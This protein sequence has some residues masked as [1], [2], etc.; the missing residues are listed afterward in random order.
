MQPANFIRFETEDL[1]PD[2]VSGNNASVL[3]RTKRAKD[4]AEQV[5][6]PIQQLPFGV[7]P[8]P[9]FMFANDK[10]Y[11]T[12]GPRKLAPNVHKSWLTVQES[13]LLDWYRAVISY[14]SDDAATGSE[15]S[16]YA[17]VYEKDLPYS[18]TITTISSTRIQIFS[19]PNNP[20]RFRTFVLAGNKQGGQW[21]FQWFISD[22][23]DTGLTDLYG[24]YA[25]TLPIAF[26]ANGFTFQ[27]VFWDLDFVNFDAENLE[28]FSLPSK[29]FDQYRINLLP[30]YNNLQGVSSGYIGLVDADGNVVDEVVGTFA[31]PADTNCVSVVLP[32]ISTNGAAPAYIS[33]ADFITSLNG[34]SGDSLWAATGFQSANYS[35]TDAATLIE[36]GIFETFGEWSEITWPTDPQ[37]FI[38]IISNFVFIEVIGEVITVGD[39]FRVRLTFCF[40]ECQPGVNAVPMYYTNPGSGETVFVTYQESLNA[41]FVLPTQLQATINMPDVPN[42]CYR[43]YLHDGYLGQVYSLSNYIQVDKADTF[44]RI[45]SMGGDG[46]LQG[47]EYIN[48]W[49]QQF[50]VPLNGGAP[51]LK[52]QDSQYRDSQGNY[53]RPSQKS[54]T[55]I[56]LHSSWIDEPTVKALFGAT[57]HS[58]LVWNGNSIFVD[59]DVEVSHPQDF[60]TDTS[61][62]ELTKVNFKAIIQQSQPTD[63]GCINC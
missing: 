55:I 21:Q 61:Y 30:E 27:D 14:A 11:S 2:F 53:R 62:S 10:Q 49:S 9:K 35:G 44:S 63:N 46:L 56:S 60:S 37:D 17:L 59:G 26:D 32:Y 29:P 19:Q 45:L 8:G 28:P 43:F 57:Q 20:N 22:K 15:L 40:P 51:E 3:A 7:L 4:Y 31:Y 5:N 42:G 6:N 1:L 54:D 34:L 48:G 12:S 25:A 41:S 58:Y 36:G 24:L 38:D 50:R 18:N 52:L 16:S 47:F 33:W 23:G 13:E 39:T